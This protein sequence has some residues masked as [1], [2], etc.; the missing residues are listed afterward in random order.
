MKKTEYL[1]IL[2]EIEKHIMRFVDEDLDR[3]RNVMDVFDA[4]DDLRNLNLRL[5]QIKDEVAINARY[6]YEEYKKSIDNGTLKF[7]ENDTDRV[8]PTRVTKNKI[9]MIPLSDSIWGFYYREQ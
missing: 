5:G 1:E 4:A 9:T 2:D 3:A 8:A 7:D 6:I